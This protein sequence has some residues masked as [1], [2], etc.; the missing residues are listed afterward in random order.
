M[1]EIIVHNQKEL[2]ALPESY[3]EYQ[4]IYINR[5]RLKTVIIDKLL[6][7]ATLICTVLGEYKK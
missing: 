1:K 3:K 6:E 5:D 2:D 7:Q 4:E